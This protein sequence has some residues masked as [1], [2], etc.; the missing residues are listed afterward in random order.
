MA[1]SKKVQ[2]VE[3]LI[4]SEIGRLVSEY[5]YDRYVLQQFAE[6][7]TTQVKSG[8]AKSSRVKRKTSSLQT[9]VEKAKALSISQLK[10]ALYEKFEVSDTKELKKSSR[11]KLATSGMESINFSK[12][13]SLEVLYRKLVGILPHEEG[14]KG[15][16]CINGIN[17][18][19]YTLP[20]K[21]FDLDPKTATTKE[22]KASYRILSKIY[23][24]DNKDTGSAEIFERIT[25]FYKSLTEKF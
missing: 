1:T 9:T 5:K 15:H 3:Y 19:K 10:Q 23:H 13:D 17:I 22:V 18:L 8:D 25:L 6:F 24:P 2:Q 16:G 21:V 20:W 12:I 11:F 7:I 4:Q 14:E